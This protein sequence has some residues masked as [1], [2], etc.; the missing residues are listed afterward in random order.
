MPRMISQGRTSNK[1]TTTR[2]QH[3]RFELVAALYKEQLGLIIKR[4]RE[5]LDLTQKQLAEKAGV[6]ESQTV[7]RWER[8]MN[9]PI[10]LEAV[11]AG[12]KTTAAEMLAELS[13]VTKQRKRSSLPAEPLSRVEAKL[14]AIIAHFKIELPPAE[15]LADVAGEVGRR[16]S[17]KQTARDEGPP[18]KK[19]KGRA[20]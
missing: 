19:R 13:P 16:R 12:L 8:G 3:A 15:T 17:G 4:R 10:D 11:A 7:S 5:D 9:A 2:A 18:V 14:D 20:A 6:E 1:P